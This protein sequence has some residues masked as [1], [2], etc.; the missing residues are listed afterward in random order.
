MIV[1]EL[2]SAHAGLGGGTGAEG[3]HATTVDVQRANGEEVEEESIGGFGRIGNMLTKG[4]VVGDGVEGRWVE[5]REGW[6]RVLTVEAFLKS[7][8]PEKLVPD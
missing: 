4:A 5:F 3:G 7:V 1:I 6:V 2:H 8:D